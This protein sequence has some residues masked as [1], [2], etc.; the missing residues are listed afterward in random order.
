MGF[1]TQNFVILTIFPLL[2]IVFFL[3]TLTPSRLQAK[4]PNKTSRE[5]LLALLSKR[6]APG[7]VQ[8]PPRPLRAVLADVPVSVLAARPRLGRAGASEKLGHPFEQ[9]SAS[10]GLL[11]FGLNTFQ[12]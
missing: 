7:P 9:G 11:Y 12:L 4:V 8:P 5:D 6:S 3:Y 1:H 2:S 10:Q